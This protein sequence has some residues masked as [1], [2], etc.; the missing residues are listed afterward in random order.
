MHRIA[1]IPQ[2][3]ITQITKNNNHH[4]HLIILNQVITSPGLRRG[5]CIFGLYYM[6]RYCWSF[7]STTQQ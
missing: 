3:I 1:A 5:K 2:I 6:D 4:V 7:I